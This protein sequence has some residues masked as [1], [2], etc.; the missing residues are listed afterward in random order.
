MRTITESFN[1]IIDK[2]KQMGYLMVEILRN[3]AN[4]LGILKTE[5]DLA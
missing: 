2:Q 3:P 5:N 1:V 4:R